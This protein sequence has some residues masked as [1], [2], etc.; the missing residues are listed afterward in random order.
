MQPYI[1]QQITDCDDNIIE[2]AEPKV[3]RQ[4][5]SEDTS[6]SV[7]AILEGVVSDGTGKN[8]QVR[9]YRVGGK[10]GTSE[11]VEQL[12]LQEDNENVLKDY[13]VSFIGF[14]PADD[15]E[16][17]ILLLLDTPSHETGLYISGG[18]MAAPCVGNMLADILPLSLG[19][20][21]RYTEDDLMEINV[22]MP[23]VT[24]KSVEEAKELLDEFGMECRVIGS[25]ESVTGQLPSSNAYVASGTTVVLY[26]GRDIPKD[27]VTVPHLTGMAYS[28]AKQ[29]LESRGLFIRTTGALR[30]D[31]RTAVSVQSI[32]AGEEAAYGTIIEVTLINK[33]A[34]ERN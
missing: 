23:R 19:I 24:G 25:G 5:I 31:S 14:A 6:A 13:I 21:P 15:P 30:S 2:A 17:I 1:V 10:T 26:A 20:M 12:T 9:G 27:D 8:A 7:R 4:V 33:D 28:E 34:V 3:I 29:A 11:N 22:D 16:I 18:G 32:P